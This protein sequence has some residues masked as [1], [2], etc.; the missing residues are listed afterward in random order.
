MYFAAA[1][2]CKSLRYWRNRLL[3]LF[4]AKRFIF[5]AKTSQRLS[6][7]RPIMMS[8]DRYLFGQNFNKHTYFL[9]F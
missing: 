8:V 9:T 7:E 4:L 5:V 2:Y 6:P 1:N 3:R